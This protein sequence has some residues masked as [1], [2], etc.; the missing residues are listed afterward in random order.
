VNLSTFLEKKMKILSNLDVDFWI[1]HGNGSKMKALLPLIS[2]NNFVSPTKNG[3]STIFINYWTV[4]DINKQLLFVTGQDLL[5][6]T[7]FFLHLF[8]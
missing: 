2:K 1:L 5:N 8:W 4:F 3:F 6:F 7:T